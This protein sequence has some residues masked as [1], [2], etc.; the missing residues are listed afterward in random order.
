MKIVFLLD[1]K[2]VKKDGIYYTTGA[3]DNNYLEK[4]KFDKED[5]LVVICREETDIKQIEKPNLAKTSGENIK[6]ITIKKYSDFYNKEINKKIKKEI[7]DS[8]F[9][10]IKL[11]TYIG[12]MSFNYVKKQNKKY[13]IEMVGCI[14]D[15]LWNYGGIKAKLLSPIM[16]LL[17]KYYIKNA[18]NVIYVS[19]NFLQNR[20][21]NKKGNT[22][23]CSDVNIYKID[24]NNLE[25][26]IK[27]IEE[28]NKSTTYKIGLIGSLNVE[29]KGHKTAIKALKLLK[30]K[31]NNNIE[32]H[33][34]G[35]GNQEKWNKIIHKCGVEKNVFFDGVLPSGEPV[36]EWM[37]SLDIY[38][39]PSLTE[40]LPRT[41]IEAMSRA[42]PAIGTKV[43]G[44]PELIIEKKCLIKRKNAK[45]LSKKLEQILKNKDE[46][47]KISNCNFNKSL[48][49]EN[50]TLQDKRKEFCKKVLGEN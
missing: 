8:D 28:Y 19:N 20:Y 45:E 10:F 22:L 27:K 17:N 11:P 5:E 7:E 36:Y 44:I 2:L 23:A 24:K 21:P 6:F 14:K 18:K 48:E 43:G 26:R 34:L 41:L 50:K 49:F 31:M 46:M 39:I 25:K 40:G 35:A 16:Y 29:Y 30:K 9:C 13:I 32:L 47:K 38:I 1:V 12:A 42:C 37:D 4:H 15:S 3:V 33:F